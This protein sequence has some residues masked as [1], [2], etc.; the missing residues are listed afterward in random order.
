M[1]RPQFR[2][3]WTFKS[4][5]GRKKMGA[6]NI[7]IS[8]NVISQNGFRLAKC[9]QSVNRRLQS[10]KTIIR[11]RKKL[12]IDFFYT[13]SINLCF[14]LFKHRPPFLFFWIIFSKYNY[15]RTILNSPIRRYIFYILT[16]VR[17]IESSSICTTM[18][19][20]H[21]IGLLVRIL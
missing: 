3:N 2:I 9:L 6:T 19:S 20:C 14:T 15:L 12:T 13:F 18:Y 4:A 17:L 5:S 21:T 16:S 1:F 7:S 11:F 10:P 8:K